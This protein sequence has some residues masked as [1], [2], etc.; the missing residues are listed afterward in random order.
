MSRVLTVLK[1]VF[2]VNISEAIE[3]AEDAEIRLVS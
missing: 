3:I 1:V 2:N